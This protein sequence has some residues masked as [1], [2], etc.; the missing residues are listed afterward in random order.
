MFAIFAV[1][2]LRDPGVLTT[3]PPPCVFRK[4][5]GI[6]CPGCGSTRALQALARGDFFLALRCNSLSV[7]ALVFLPFLFILRG[8]KFRLL[9]RRFI[10]ALAAALLVFFILRNLPFPAFDFLRPPLAV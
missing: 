6:Y 8:P 3:F 10:V 5:T 7:A 4:A 2:V 9:Y 1:A